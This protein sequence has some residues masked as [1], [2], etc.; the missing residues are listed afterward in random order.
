M[1]FYRRK[2]DAKRYWATKPLC[3]VCKQHKVKSGTICHECKKV[4]GK[5][6][7]SKN[8]E[9]IVMDTEN[10]RNIDTETQASNESFGIPVSAGSQDKIVRLFTYLE[11]ALALDDT[12]V[13]DFRSSMI[14]PSPW[15]LSDYPRDLENLFIREF[16]TEKDVS[17]DDRPGA[18][19]RVQKKN[20]E[21][22][23][24]LSEKLI[25]WVVDV[26]PLDRPRALEKI[27]RKVRFDNNKELVDEF[28]KFRNDFQQGD[29]VPQVLADWVVLAPNKLPEA[30]EV[31]YV[32][33]NW[34][35]HPE[36]EKLLTG[37]A[38]N[39]WEQWAEKVKKAYKANLLYDQLYALRLLLKN[40]GDS[41]ELLLGHGL[42]T[43]KHSSV[44][45]IYAPI[46]FTPLILDFDASKRTI[47]INPDPMFR[48]FVEIAPVSEMDNPAEMDLDKWMGAVNSS[49][50]DFWHLETLRSQANTFLNYLSPNAEDRFTDESTSAPTLTDNPA[51]WNA[52]IIF[53]RKRTNS[54]W[55]KYAETIKRDIE[56]N[57]AKSTEFI[58]DLIGEYEEEKE[59]TGIGDG[60]KD[61][62]TTI[63]ESE[64]LFPLPWNEEQKRIAERIET[65][66]GVVVK[67]PPGTGKSH[68]IA[69][70][71][72][73][74]LAQGKS[75]LVTSQTSKA[76]EVLRGKL[77]ENIRSLA[78][79]QLHQ[80]AKRDDVLQ[81]SITEISSNLG[82]RDTKFSESKA[83]F[84]RKE[85]ASVREEKA[86]V[87]NL[88]RQYILTDSTQTLKA[89]GGDV[90]PIE[91]A[92]FISE[93]DKD[94]N[95]A[96]FTDEVH[97][98]TELNF[99]AEDLGETYRLLTELSRDDRDL[100]KFSL[101][102]LSTLPN[103]DVVSGAFTS[104]R[105]LSSKAK[106]SN[107]V[108][109]N[110]GNDFNQEALSK[111]WEML[112]D[113]RKVLI[114]INEGYER[115]IFTA[116]ITSQSERE[117]WTTILAKISE[118]VLII[119]KSRN[120]I[121][122]HDISGSTS[123][124]LNELADAI[125]ALKSKV[126]N[127][128]KLGTFGKML[129][130][131]NAKKILQSYSV[132]GRC[133]DNLEH[134]NLLSEM[135]AAQIAEKEIKVLLDQ[136]F[137]N[138]KQ[139]PDWLKG[140]I[141]LIR[142]EVLVAGTERV[143]NYYKKFLLIDESFK[144]V[145]QLSDLSFTRLE[146]IESARELIASSVAQFELSKLEITFN[147]WV[148]LIDDNTSTKH[149]VCDRLIQAIEKVN[150]TAWKKA[151][152][153]LSLLR[154]NK[155][156][157]TRLAEMTERIKKNA[158]NL[159]G[160]IVGLADQKERFDCPDNLELAWKIARLKSWLDHIHDHISIDELQSKHERLSKREFQLN[161]DLV[162]ILAWQRQIDKV[163][164]RQRDALMAW[165]D[166][167]RKYGKGTGKWAHKHLAAAQESLREAKNAV[168]VW[169]MPL[170][171]AAQ[172]FSDPK[173]GMF[174]VVI[175][176]EASQCDI[177]GLTIGYLGKK[178]LV[179]GDPDQI[180]PA[181]IF[182]DQERVYELISRFLYDIPHKD[183]F[184]IT[185]S[186]FGLAQIRIPNM[187]QLNEHFR[188]V[189]EIIAFSNHHI[190][191][192]KLKPLRHPHPKGLLKPALIPV[193]VEGGYQNT[194]N[195][196]NEPEAK[197]IVDKI[198]EFLENPDYQQRPNG[199]LCTFG[200]IS[201]L[202]DDQ[203]KYIKELLL[204]HPKIGEK[205]IEERNI[206]C[207]D[208]YAFQ[209]DERDVMFLSM[210]KA[211]DSNDLNDTVKAL[212]DK[213]TA[214]RFNVAATRG[215]DQVFLY[216]SIPVHEFRN[217]NDWR[218]KILN[219]YYDPKTEELEA[220]RK[221]LKKEFDS[222][223]ASQF[224]FDVGNI[225]I[226]RGYQVL[227]EYPVIGYRIDLVV[228]G[229]NARLAVE[230]DGDQYHTLEN[231]EDDQVRERQLRRAGWEFWRV[232][233]SSF[234]RHKEKALDSLW[235][236]LDEFEIKPLN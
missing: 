172:M 222:G 91:A 213:G 38:E 32:S 233:G 173:A 6:V 131:A 51:I 219:W 116:C 13:R 126:S 139:P 98:N 110:S 231:W 41:H 147:E 11:K 14:P 75:V 127:N 95:L 37:Y 208:A 159:L 124:T 154:T 35:D 198:A 101:P 8:K 59:E 82:D 133:P 34:I 118:K 63:K 112:N 31:K 137:L 215:R 72:A 36:L 93:H 162:T 65:N 189:P 203:A 10:T 132:D 39:E 99:G 226:D 90:T 171:R 157:A 185:S 48:S 158:P 74:F 1:V 190:Y 175:F 9:T 68:T 211:L 107:K 178:L 22:A 161:S 164:K 194:N 152:E 66:Y 142:L 201:L 207:G 21:S 225:L 30:I 120:A 76:L 160:D 53:V 177:R 206:V 102:D 130:P 234:Y 97:F 61:V 86:S 174:D 128:T 52:P 144:K 55:S 85:L 218:Y 109:G 83:E 169:I 220:G 56:Q 151:V 20:I 23:P 187:I 181:G 125:V 214:Q 106:V 79:S 47:E 232:S 236:K 17:N 141:D 64:L 49:P 71:I 42:L 89:N 119:G 103:E 27:A 12:I 92:K 224:S 202:A 4:R 78:V 150:N 145:K 24:I 200:V 60:E 136:G 228:Q 138:L 183:N 19:L 28:R 33:D 67:G 122:G 156:K 104:Y 96:W 210:V 163:T 165:S 209:G 62:V 167:M 146:N 105:E 205:I 204:R 196:V 7:H 170:H 140:D 179:V 191:E 223:R 135:T 15:W 229:E 69:N 192:G 29:S 2:F 134:I 73:R 45:A 77:P 143:V 227:P 87:A 16:E 121:V 3:T 197:A 166:S 5:I 80:T 115:E 25:E 40:E 186:L 46:F 155:E 230:C 100:Y 168:P 43:W 193:L 184:S 123:L 217:Q 195:K 182:Q 57:G 111:L 88:I 129:L 221:A 84:F 117:K 212:T 113:A 54:L 108:F 235:K 216:H 114:A 176:D 199:D 26:N 50:F 58:N 70:L 180:S 44:G 188:C 81:Q 149:G 153:E 94:H 18:W 148:E